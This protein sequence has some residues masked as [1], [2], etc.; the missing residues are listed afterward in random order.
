MQIRQRSGAPLKTIGGVSSPSV[1]RGMNSG[2][3]SRSVAIGREPAI[4]FVFPSSGFQI[5]LFILV[6]MS[7][8]RIHEHFGFLAALRP[9]L[10]LTALALVLAVID[11][12]QLNTANLSTFPAKMVAA[13]V[14]TALI[15]VPFGI[16]MGNSGRFLLENYLKIIFVFVLVLL[17][18]RSARDLSNFVWAYVLAVTLL[19]WMAIF[20]FQLGEGLGG[21]LRLNSLYTYDSN[22]LGVFLLMGIPLTMVVVETSGRAGKAFG[23]AV[24]SAIGV[25]I[26]RGGSR[27]TFVGLISLVLAYLLWANHTSLVKRFMAVAILASALALAAPQGYWSQMDSLKT[28]SED[29]NWSAES[30][31]RNLAKRGFGYMMKYPLSGVGIANFNKAEWQLSSMAQEVGRR[32]GIRGAVAHNTWVQVGAELGVTGLVSWVVLIFGSMW[33]VARTRKQLPVSWKRG[34]PEQRVL[35]SLSFYLPLAI[36]AFAVPSTFVSHAY[37]DPMYFLAALSAGYL[38]AVRR[39]MGLGP[40]TR[41]EWTTNVV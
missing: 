5:V 2:P 26:A 33:A 35:Y 10:G 21:Q 29:Y 31:R 32:K 1:P 8:S 27:G 14:L 22:D 16:S 11:L 23:F 15:S 3:R 13:V 41:E 4:E 40:K 7:I 34:S 39:E 30:G 38:V 20:L 12:R 19:C 25:S 17:A 9:G 37:M 6:V 36:W 28:P 18:Q 24:L